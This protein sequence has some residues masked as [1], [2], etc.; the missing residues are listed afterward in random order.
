MKNEI[1]KAIQKYH[2]ISTETLLEISAIV[3]REVKKECILFGTWYSG[4][5]R[6]KVGHAYKH[7]LKEQPK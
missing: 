1:A 3:D 7:Y 5:D 6:S 2:P 4:M